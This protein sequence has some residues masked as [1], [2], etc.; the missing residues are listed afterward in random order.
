MLDNKISKFDCIFCEKLW[1]KQVSLIS[2][3]SGYNK[4]LGHDVNTQKEKYRLFRSFY[5]LQES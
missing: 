4:H 3:D 1:N 2:S 5:I